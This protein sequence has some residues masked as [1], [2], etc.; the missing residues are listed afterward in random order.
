MILLFVLSSND[1]NNNDILRYLLDKKLVIKIIE[2][3]KI[4]KS[5]FKNTIFVQNISYPTNFINNFIETLNDNLIF[6]INCN[7]I[8][9]LELLNQINRY[10]NYDLLLPFSLNNIENYLKNNKYILDFKN[11]P[12]PIIINRNTF[13]NY[14]KFNTKLKTV[15][16][17]IL[18][19]INKIKRF[20][21]IIKTLENKLILY[22]F[23][24]EYNQ[25]DEHAYLYF[26]KLTLTEYK[27]K[28]NVYNYITMLDLGNWGLA[29]QMFQY[30]MLYTLSKFLNCQLVFLN[31]EHIKLSIFPKIKLN[32]N[33][34]N[35]NFYTY[36]EENFSYYDIFSIVNTDFFKKKN[37]EFKGFFQSDKYFDRFKKEIINIFSLSTI[38]DNYI[39]SIMKKTNIHN[40]PTVSI[41]VR[42]G[43]YSKY[44][45]YHIIVDISYYKTCIEEFPNH[46]F[47]VFSD[48]KEW[49]R[50]NLIPYLNNYYISNE[51]DYIDLFMMS[52]CNHNIIANSTFSWW[53]GYLNKNIDKKIYAPSPWF[54]E[55]GIKHH[56]LYLDDWTIVNYKSK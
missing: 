34:K 36:K 6:F 29:N 52:K 56:S 31:N 44:M 37:I 18:D 32:F 9:R 55:K 5:K 50:K 35:I 53:A 11:I 42:R 14:K 10:E 48:D 46:F 26:K 16:Y 8:L 28:A 12:I 17:I 21:L 15:N 38:E 27:Q 4:K 2:Y 1:I 54:G 20:D 45:D 41:H 43:D 33:S 49:C 40:L 23:I 39:N 13:I 25:D 3:G 22:N 7:M 51:K 19:Y 30:A 47:F 24:H